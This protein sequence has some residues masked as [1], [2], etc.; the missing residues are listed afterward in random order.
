MSQRSPSAE[1][2]IDACMRR[3]CGFNRA[4]RQ[5]LQAQFHWGTPPPAAEP[6]TRICMCRRG[7]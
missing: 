4:A 5:L 2:A 7:H 1:T 6:S 3:N